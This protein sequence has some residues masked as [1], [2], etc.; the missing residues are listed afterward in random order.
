M[1]ASI[2]VG[3]VLIE[4]EKYRIVEANPRAGKMVGVAPEEMLGQVCRKFICPNESSKCPVTELGT[5]KDQAEH[6]LL[7]AKGVLV[8]ILKSVVPVFRKGKKYLLE[9]F[10]DL[11]GQRGTEE[12]LAQ[13][14]AHPRGP[15]TG[16]GRCRPPPTGT[17]QSREQH[18]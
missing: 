12:A 14:N 3:V 2:G 6:H 15:S 16:E 1:T 17:A 11:T 7:T 13:A 8:P 4:A 9:S 10:V 18:H 5:F